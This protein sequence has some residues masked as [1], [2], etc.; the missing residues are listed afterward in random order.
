MNFKCGFFLLYF[1]I[2]QFSFSQGKKITQRISIHLGGAFPLGN[3]GS[4]DIQKSESGFANPGV[5]SSVTYY[6]FFKKIGITAAL[7]GQ[8]NPIDNKQLE[9]AFSKTEMGYPFVISGPPQISNTIQEGQQNFNKLNWKFESRPWFI[10][11]LLIGGV[12]RI[13]IG[14]FEHLYFTPEVSLGLGHIR[15]PK[16]N[17]EGKLNVTTPYYSY[18]RTANYSQ[19]DSDTFGFTYRIR[20]GW[21]YESTKQFSLLFSL[22]YFDTNK[23]KFK[24]LTSEN[25]AVFQ[26]NTF[27]GG[28]SATPH[29]RRYIGQQVIQSINL[30]IGLVKNF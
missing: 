18:T 19:T 5:V 10:T 25:I 29:S 4:N 21:E 30:G 7:F 11:S 22:D 14:R 27:P 13:K 6:H 26:N 23:V 1:F 16:I 28:Y 2:C 24:Y 9:K 3:Y 20:S 8:I 15:I 17:G 12:T